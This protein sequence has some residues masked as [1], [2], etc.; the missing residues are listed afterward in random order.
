MG[1]DY[2]PSLRCGLPGLILSLETAFILIFWFCFSNESGS[3]PKDL[4]IYPAFQDVN[5]LVIFGFGFLLAFTKRYGFSST[6]FNLLIAAL[7]VQWAMLVEG[8]LFSSAAGKVKISLHR[9][10]TPV[11]GKGIYSSNISSTV[12]CKKTPLA[13]TTHGQDAS[14]MSATNCVLKASISVTAVLISAGALLGKANPIQLIWMAMVEVAAFSTSRWIN[15]KFLKVEEHT[16]LMH[17]HI[18]GTYFGLAVSWWLY[19]SSL[20]ERIEKEK[21]NQI[22]DLFSMLGTLFLWMFWP[23]FNSVLIVDLMEKRNAICNTYYA[24]AVSAVAAFA[25]SSLSSRNGKIRMIHIHHAA[26]A[27]GVALGFS[28]PIIPHPWIAMILG[29]LASMVA[30]LGSHCFE[31][32][33]N[34]VLKIHD[35]CGVH[36]TFGLPG[37]LGAIV[38][39][40]LFIIIKWASLSSLGYLAL[41]EVGSFMLTTA[42]GLGTGF[43][44]GF[45]LTFKLWKTLPASKYFD[46]QAFWE[47]PH[48][49][50]GF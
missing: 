20:S 40:I 9:L 35:T 39:V 8:F 25:L 32:Y 16:S 29:L 10:A 36:Y 13:I 37:L 42:I 19:H 18:F 17:V 31:T 43:V 5:V 46:D 26:L 4:D 27:G 21:S 22:S 34:S 47:F 24:I 41:I 50:Y 1:S 12:K 11:Y 7:G 23:S 3:T 33:L 15:V 38:H 2:P 30:V 45:V 6:G 28:A 44:T 14:K 49:A 48:L